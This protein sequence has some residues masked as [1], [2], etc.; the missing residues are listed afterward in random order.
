M[1]KHIAKHL[2]L[3]LPYEFGE[4][5]CRKRRS[6]THTNDRLGE[7]GIAT[8]RQRDEQRETQRAQTHSRQME[9]PESLQAAL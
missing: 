6:K 1:N 8:N 5:P 9:E 4:E 2:T 7:T 3:S